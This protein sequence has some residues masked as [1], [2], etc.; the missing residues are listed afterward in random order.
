MAK[1]CFINLSLSSLGNL[2]SCLYSCSKLWCSY[3]QLAIYNLVWS[4]ESLPFHQST[5]SLV[6]SSSPPRN[7]RISLTTSSL[8]SPSNPIT[9]SAPSTPPSLEL[10]KP[11]NY[12]PPKL[13]PPP[14]KVNLP[15]PKLK[16]PPT[17]LKL[18][19]LPLFSMLPSRL[20][21]EVMPLEMHANQ[22]QEQTYQPS[23]HRRRAM[24]V[25]SD[26]SY[27]IAYQEKPKMIPFC[28]IS[29]IHAS[30][31]DQGQILVSSPSNDVT[32]DIYAAPNY[33]SNWRRTFDHNSISS[34]STVSSD[35]TA[36]I[37]HGTHTPP[38]ENRVSL[39]FNDKKMHKYESLNL[40]T[41]DSCTLYDSPTYAKVGNE[42]DEGA[43]NE[44][45]NVRMN[46][47]K[48]VQIA[49]EYAWLNLQSEVISQCSAMT[50]SMDGEYVQPN[51]VVRTISTSPTND[52]LP[53]VELPDYISL[54]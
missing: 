11:P 44:A 46:R 12:P 16:T 8:I 49:M 29:G 53:A 45:E 47:N 15:S 18:P 22:F 17:K 3:L 42:R 33:V 50:E 20:M 34:V 24:T 2:Y 5:T 19:L 10:A 30:I 39:C 27:C 48:R 41:M 4:T 43:D 31:N 21:D 54:S 6:S 51:D 9:Q 37:N 7:H 23:L 28:D 13:T 38:D 1:F 32:D 40:E 52:E 35:V 14:P 25:A 26:M 36:I